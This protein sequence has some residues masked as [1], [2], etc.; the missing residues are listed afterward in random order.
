MLL[1][2]YPFHPDCPISWHIVIHSNF[3]PI[4]FTLVVS[5][6]TLQIIFLK[7]MLY[8]QQEISDSICFVL[9]TNE[10]NIDY[11]RQNMKGKKRDY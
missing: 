8:I 3:L 10:E 6:V 9:L 5:V 2:I 11:I 1:E 7:K 4:L